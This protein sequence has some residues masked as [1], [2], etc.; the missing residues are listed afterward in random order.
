MDASDRNRGSAPQSPPQ[1]AEQ[2]RWRDLVSA[3]GSEVASPLTAALERI[4]TLIATGR[5]DR[6]SLRALR[7]EVDGARRAGMIAQQLTRFAS[8]RLRQSHERLSLAQTMQSVLDQRPRETAKRGIALQPPSAA[9]DVIVDASLLFS[10]CN[11]LLDWTLAFARSAIRFEVDLKDWPVHA[12]L[13]CRFAIQPKTGA[14]DPTPTQPA[15]NLDSLSWRLIEQ[16]AK[17]M[18]LPLTRDLHGGDVTVRVE[19]PRTASDSMEG[20]STIEID[21]E[22]S[23]QSTDSKP[24]AGSHVLVIASRREMRVR[25]CDAIRHL[26]LVIDLVNS[27]DEAAK[28]CRESLPDAIIVEGILRGE[29]LNYL[30][31]QVGAQREEFPFIEITEEGADFQMSGYD[32]KSMGRVGRD[33]IETALASV[34]TFELS[35]TL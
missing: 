4:Q 16:T 2:D 13:V 23:L 32:G 19:F 28:F 21:A 10:L 34:L 25:V 20:M 30:R 14:A 3:V 6:T 22:N 17:A 29:R 1:S 9:A 7:D 31:A 27:V 24:L 35:R 8:G 12:C 5:I 18:D 26:G 33:A 15:P 11:T